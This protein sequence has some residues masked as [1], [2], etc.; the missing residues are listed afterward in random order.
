MKKNCVSGIGKILFLL[1][2]VSSV[3]FTGCIDYV[4]PNLPPYPESSAPV[5]KQFKNVVTGKRWYTGAKGLSNGTT[6][7]TRITFDSENLTFVK[8]TFIWDNVGNRKTNRRVDTTWARYGCR[9]ISEW[10]VEIKYMITDSNYERVDSDVHKMRCVVECADIANFDGVQFVST[11]ALAG[12]GI[13]DHTG[14]ESW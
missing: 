9:F 14:H 11:E 13:V 12:Q 3:M 1:V 5:F 10:D 4:D 2:L 8:E 7:Q 6:V